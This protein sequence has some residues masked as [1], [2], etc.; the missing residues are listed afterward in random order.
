MRKEWLSNA[1]RQL[2]YCR[3]QEGRPTRTG[4]AAALIHEGETSG[5]RSPIDHFRAKSGRGVTAVVGE[6]LGPRITCLE[7]E[8]ILEPVIELSLQG[9]V[10]GEPK[11]L[12]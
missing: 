11:I 5:D 2:I 7:E 3:D 9:L 8:T 4:N 1:D 6:T 12:R 10:V